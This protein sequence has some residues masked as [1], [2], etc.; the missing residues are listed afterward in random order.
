MPDVLFGRKETY[1]F[2]SLNGAVPHMD[3]RLSSIRQVL[4][5]LLFVLYI[6]NMP[7]VVERLI[8]LFANNT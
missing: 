7:N 3:K 2:V 5:P 1:I 4:G 6:N 8:K